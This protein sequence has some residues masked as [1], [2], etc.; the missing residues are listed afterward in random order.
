MGGGVA[1]ATVLTLANC[2][3]ASN[4]ASAGGGID[5]DGNTDILSTTIAYNQSS[6]AGSGG[7]LFNEVAGAILYY[8]IIARNTDNT[9]ADDIGGADVSSY[10]IYGN[11]IGT[12]GS[13]GLTCGT[14]GNQVGVADPGLA[15]KLASNGGPT[16]T[17]ALLAGSPAIVPGVNYNS[18]VPFLTSYPFYIEGYWWRGSLFAQ[19]T[20]RA[21]SREL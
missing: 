11:L 2:T 10:A 5:N 6:G 18:P 21:G 9:G 13:G 4:S 3:I 16:Q 12:G 8:T 17:I 19:S 14:Y 7:G 15:A 1:N 20:D